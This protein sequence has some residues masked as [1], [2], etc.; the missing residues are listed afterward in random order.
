MKYNYDKF[1]EKFGPDVH[2]DPVRF[3][4]IAKLCKG[5]ILDVGCGTGT[6]ADFYKGN[7]FGCDISKVAIKMAKEIRNKEAHF[8]VFDFC[9]PNDEITG[10]YDTI[11]L[12]EFLEHIEDD[13]IVLKNLL[14][15]S[16]E[17]SRWVI[18]VPNGDRIPDESH[19]RQFT[20]PELRKKFKDYGKVKFYNWPGAEKRILMTVDLGQKNENLLGLCMIL[21]NEALGLEK[22]VLSCLN[23]VDEIVLA[24]DNSS[25]DDTEKIAKLYADTLKN[26]KWKNSFCQ[27]RNE[28]QKFC[29]TKYILALDGHEYVESTGSL[30]FL[31][32]DQYD[33]FFV[34][35]KLE[36]NFSFNFPRIVKKEVNWIKDV[37]NSPEV[38]K[39]VRI[40]DFLIVHDRAGL[41]SKNA[42]AIRDAQ[43]SKMVFE[44]MKKES[45]ENPKN[46]RPYFYMGQQSYVER[47]FKQAI[48][49]YKKYLKYSKNRGERW[50]TYYTIAQ[51]NTLLN[52]Y[53]FA[54]WNLAKAE[55]EEPNRW[56]T[57]QL[58]GLI[59]AMAG[60]DK[61]ALKYLVDSF[62]ENIGDFLYY[63]EIKNPADTWQLI[64]F[65]FYR[66]G[67]LFQAKVAWN[68][69]LELA[70]DE[71]VKKA[72]SQ[73]LEIIKR[74]MV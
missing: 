25:I 61:K 67:D 39:P 12:A 73:N 72:M 21:K 22:A 6:L 74:M 7:Y 47:K 50:L 27:A 36:N 11:V 58:T 43:R 70:K 68:R 57:S 60:W 13:P 30:D 24:V 34:K 33:G 19:I 5:D 3:T 66:K 18:S 40:P 56:E 28:A 65:L 44:I 59:Y 2:F 15:L 35:I 46:P 1:F 55:K 37:H 23:F 38:K 32:K 8:F 26:Y 64:G 42:K 29:T 41:Q 20:I 51:C 62:K 4:E 48:R 52:R 69:A 10:K 53:F 71:S 49:Y 31:K 9:S 63:P 17:N 45:K 14:K 54:L 16:K